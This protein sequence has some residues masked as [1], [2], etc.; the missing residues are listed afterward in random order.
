MLR[1]EPEEGGAVTGKA[2]EAEEQESARG[3]SGTHAGATKK[4]SD[5]PGMVEGAF[6]W[7]SGCVLLH[8]AQCLSRVRALEGGLG[9]VRT[10]G[11]H[12]H[13]CETVVV[14]SD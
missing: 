8:A 6:L 12:V 11:S 3:W 13:S 14:L 10:F 7:K 9:R 4:T 2:E 5:A 1:G